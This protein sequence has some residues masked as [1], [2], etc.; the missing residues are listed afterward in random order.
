[1]QR[2]SLTFGLPNNGYPGDFGAGVHLQLEWLSCPADSVDKTNCEGIHVVNTG[3]PCF[4]HEPGSFFGA[5]HEWCF[6]LVEYKY[7]VVLLSKYLPLR[8]L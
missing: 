8:A 2:I 3:S 1:M 4:K 5:R 6:V 7:H